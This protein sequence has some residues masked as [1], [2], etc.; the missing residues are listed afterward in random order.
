M[1]NPGINSGASRRPGGPVRPE[2]KA[3]VAARNLAE[4]KDKLGA[5]AEAGNSQA[6]AIIAGYEKQYLD[7]ITADATDE[8]TEPVSVNS[9]DEEEDGTESD[10]PIAPTVE[11]IDRYLHALEAIVYS[12]TVVLTDEQQQTLERTRWTWRKI[13]RP[14][15]DIVECPLVL[16]CYKNP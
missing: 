14:N 8:P 15:S 7:A 16:L 12:A 4:V 1:A 2:S 5:S 6:A 10:R 11:S 13:P 3:H 9:T